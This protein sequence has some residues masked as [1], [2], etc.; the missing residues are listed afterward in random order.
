MPN[1]PQLT[2]NPLYEPND[3]VTNRYI[4]ILKNASRPELEEAVKKGDPPLAAAATFLLSKLKGGWDAIASLWR[5]TPEDRVMKIYSEIVHGHPPPT[6]KEKITK[7]LFEILTISK[8]GLAAAGR[9]AGIA[10]QIF[11]P[12]KLASIIHG[13]RV[14]YMNFRYKLLNSP[15]V[16]LSGRSL[17]NSRYASITKQNFKNKIL[18]T[19]LQII[20]RLGGNENDPRI[21][22]LLSKK[23][24]EIGVSI[25][26]AQAIAAAAGKLS[27]NTGRLS[28]SRYEVIGTPKLYTNAQQSLET[29]ASQ[30]GMTP[31][32]VLKDP[33][34]AII[35][36]R[37]IAT[38]GG[39]TMSEENAKKLYKRLEMDIAPLNR[40]SKK[41]YNKIN[42]KNKTSIAEYLEKYD[43]SLNELRKIPGEVA[44]ATGSPLQTIKNYINKMKPGAP[45]IGG[46]RYNKMTS[47]Q[48][49]RVPPGSTKLSTS[50]MEAFS[51]VLVN[52]GTIPPAFAGLQ[53]PAGG[54]IST[55]ILI[56]NSAKA[57]LSSQFVKMSPQ[58]AINLAIKYRKMN[59]AN[60]EFAALGVGRI[61]QNT[62]TEN[63]MRIQA[64]YKANLSNA[65]R[66][67]L[68]KL[69]S[70]K[71]RM[72]IGALRNGT[73][74]YDRLRMWARHLGSNRESQYYSNFRSALQ[75]RIRRITNNRNA[76]S[77]MRRLRNLRSAA[78]G[79]GANR[80]I[81]SAERE[82]M[83]KM[84]REQNE[85]R[86]IQNA[87]RTSRGLA[88]MYRNRNRGIPYSI[89]QPT[90]RGYGNMQVAFEAPV[91]RPQYGAVPRPMPRIPNMPIMANMGRQSSPPLPQ[92]PLENILPPAEKN[93]VLNVG[94][95][96]KA[97]NLVENA[98]GASNVVK[99]ANIMRNV[100]GSPEAAVAAGANAKNVKIVLQ[101]GGPNNA[102]K[103]AAAVPKLKRRRSKKKVPKKKAPKPARVKEIKKLLGFLGA[104]A[105]LQKKL[106]DKNNRE[107]KLSKKEIVGKLTRFL[108]RK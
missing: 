82:I 34:A 39:S 15:K 52:G 91:N 95:A 29:L 80:N 76:I 20:K 38:P 17:L 72:A 48:E 78:A 94:G 74:D 67:R 27:M 71:A 41:R 90:P 96:N 44:A 100:G 102:V 57:R 19:K 64:T 88:P 85:K 7:K 89:N 107:K 11:S 79:M 1:A 56:S 40:V 35:L 10:L 108:L 4:K 53:I 83:E 22:P 92:M 28:T 43:I 59:S 14:K 101:L 93:A 31:A 65:A 62:K 6:F 32:Q 84:R 26:P 42:F 47:Q 60:A 25:S 73:L 87:N 54:N 86:R 58:E 18:K 70:S 75:N 77:S 8:T 5:T 21:G 16:A 13:D 2:N 24:K 69:V 49:A 99:T 23:L 68:N 98:G 61:G 81:E 12:S 46:G 36:A 106:P 30:L 103:V 45:R 3:I 104:K 97:I 63:L 33:R 50:N 66:N 9:A 51:R 105:N 55:G 37:M